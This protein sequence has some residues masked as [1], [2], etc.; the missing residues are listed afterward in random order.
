MVTFMKTV[1][2]IVLFA[3]AAYLPVSYAGNEVGAPAQHELTPSER[4]KLK[5]WVLSPATSDS[6]GGYL[7]NCKGADGKFFR[8]RVLGPDCVVYEQLGPFVVLSD[9]PTSGWRKVQSTSTADYYLDDTSFSYIDDQ[10]TPKPGMGA[11]AWL[12]VAFHQPQP[13]AHGKNRTMFTTL[14]TSLQQ[15]CKRN[16]IDYG[17]AWLYDADGKLVDAYPPSPTWILQP[18]NPMAPALSAYCKTSGAH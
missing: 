13:V 8:T 7:F 15:N 11:E 1:A 17:I 16:T 2:R 5:A 9:T 3:I 12:K 14:V 10:V 6:Q 4:A 18:Q